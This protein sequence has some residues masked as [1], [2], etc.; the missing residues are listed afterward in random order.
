[1]NFRQLEIFRAVMDTGSATAA[2]RLLG[3][4]QPAVS[5]QLMQLETEVGL[6]LFARERGKLIPTA[7]AVAR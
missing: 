2:A 1:M 5:R 6:D 3:L 7:H 4:S